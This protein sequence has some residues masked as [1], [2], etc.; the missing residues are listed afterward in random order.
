M[1]RADGLRLACMEGRLNSNH[2]TIKVQEAPMH[3]TASL[4]PEIE[5]R[6]RL[7]PGIPFPDELVL[8]LFSY[9]NDLLLFTDCSFYS[10]IP[11]RPNSGRH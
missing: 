8:F 9:L 11:S 7:L 6:E 2:S 4:I 10:V 5:G 3:H 1:K